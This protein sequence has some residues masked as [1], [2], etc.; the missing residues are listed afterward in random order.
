MITQPESNTKLDES[1]LKAIEETKTRL[2]NLESEISIA[3]KNL[4]VIKAETESVT[5]E[6]IYQVGLL[7]DIESKLQPK[8]GELESL[9][10]KIIEKSEELGSLSKES[11]I[12]KSQNELKANE[13]N[14]REAGIVEKEKNVQNSLNSL[15]DRRN[16][17]EE[18]TK[19]FNSKV[20]KLKEVTATF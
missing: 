20:A 10:Q 17:L 5:K 15:A 1:Q 7:S 9:E 8:K 19:V 16:K 18:D 2:I 14:D 12:I 11:G 6:H 3:T 4:R 13:L